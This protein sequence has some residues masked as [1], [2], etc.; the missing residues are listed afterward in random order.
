VKSV[1]KRLD[2]EDPSLPKK[3]RRP[4]RIDNCFTPETYHDPETTEDPYRKIYEALDNV[5]ETISA[6]FDQPDWAV[7]QN[8][9][10]LFMKTLNG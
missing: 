1:Q 2:I 6:R 5:I 7:H 10:Q 8:M 4:A 3:K 9:Q